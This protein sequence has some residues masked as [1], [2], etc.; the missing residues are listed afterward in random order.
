MTM[1]LFTDISIR[2]FDYDLPQDKIA[3]YPLP[4]RD[5]SA[6]L[7]RDKDGKIKS[8]IFR[9]LS[10]YLPGD[11]NLVF[12]NSRVIPARMFFPAANGGFTEIFCLEPVNPAGYAEMMQST[13]SCRWKCMIGN[14]KNFNKILKKEIRSDG[15]SIYIEAKSVVNEGL[16]SIL[17]FTW[18]D[19]CITFGEIILKAGIT[20]LPPYIKREAVP[21]DSERY[22]TVYSKIDGSVAAP[23]AGLH[24]TPGVLN[25]LERKKMRMSDI[26]L[27]VGSGT[28]LPVKGDSIS[29]HSM[30]SEY[31]SVTRDFIAN[32]ADVKGPVIP[33]GTTSLRTLESLYWLG[34][35]TETGIKQ[36]SEAL[37][38]DQWEPYNLPSSVPLKKAF[39]NLLDWMDIRQLGTL[40]GRTRLM[41]LPGYPFRVADAVITN[42]HQ[43]KSTLLLLIAAF[44]GD[45]WKN[46]YKY[47]LE[48]NFR[49]LSYGDSS[50]LF[51]VQI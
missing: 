30:H 39:I 17:D 22:Q 49:F 10:S 2:D 38:L 48:N 50:L 16:T 32:F 43:P 29:E 3:Y 36:S 47:A 21:D 20:P 25:D 24:F 9:N 44:I 6:L 15:K 5:K 12:N 11:A 42:F 23:T 51:R 18:N 28:F 35:K 1:E 14:R 13:G 45:A 19:A 31:F 26:T 27:H 41:I 40:T 34:V 4:E 46:V 37:S 33:V 8:D 7:I